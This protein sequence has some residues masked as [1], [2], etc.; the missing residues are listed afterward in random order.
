M[1]KVVCKRKSSEELT[2]DLSSG[3]CFERMTIKRLR[4]GK[5]TYSLAVRCSRF[6]VTTPTAHTVF[7]SFLHAIFY[8]TVVNEQFDVQDI[9]RF[10][11]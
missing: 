8:V 9:I 3:V 5:T 2:I 10:H 1:G 11:C 4:L 6:T 7:A